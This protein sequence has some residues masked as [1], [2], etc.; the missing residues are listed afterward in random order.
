MCW[1]LLEFCMYSSNFHKTWLISLYYLHFPE[2]KVKFHSYELAFLPSYR[3]ETGFKR[4][5]I[6][7]QS[8]VAIQKNEAK[9]AEMKDEIKWAQKN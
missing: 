2:Q 5:S 4:K 1:A 8:C 3:Q 6:W 9:A 7:L